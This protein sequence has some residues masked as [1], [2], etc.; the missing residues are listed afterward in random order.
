MPAVALIYLELFNT[1]VNIFQERF[2]AL[3][4]NFFALSKLSPV[5][6]RLYESLKYN[7]DHQVVLVVLC[8]KQKVHYNL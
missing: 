7:D 6:E 2:H 3:Y 5:D 8:V 4:L 1:H